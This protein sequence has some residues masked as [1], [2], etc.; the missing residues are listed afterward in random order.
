M[1]KL[2]TIFCTT[3]LISANA[4]AFD[5]FVGADMLHT[6]SRSQ[7]LSQDSKIGSSQDASDKGYGLS[8]G[9]RQDLVLVFA[10]AEL[11]YDSLDLATGTFNAPSDQGNRI[12]I[13]RR[14]GGKVNAGI[15]LPFIKPFL[16]F[17]FANVDYKVTNA[18]SGLKHDNSKLAPIYGIGALLDLPLD[19][20]LKASYDFQ[21]FETSAISTGSKFRNNIGVARIGLIYHF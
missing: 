20:S 7:I 9:V 8:F 1:K 4:N 15:V 16:T 3:F 21:Q 5:F 18:T 12:A 19:I 14:Y 17:G 2:L 10:S 6:D 13:D 11:F